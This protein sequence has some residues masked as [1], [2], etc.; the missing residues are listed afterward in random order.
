MM[1]HHGAKYFGV[2]MLET[3]SWPHLVHQVHSHFGVIT[4]I[5]LTD[6]V[7]QRTKN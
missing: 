7:E 6:V 5:S 1:F 3:E 4:G 2:V